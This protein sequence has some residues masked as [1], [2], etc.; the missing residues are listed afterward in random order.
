MDKQM[1]QQIIQSLRKDVMPKPSTPQPNDSATRK[2][3]K[4]WS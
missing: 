1:L 3:K 4:L 2:L